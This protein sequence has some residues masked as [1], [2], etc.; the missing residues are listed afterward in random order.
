MCVCVR[1]C[2]CSF[3]CGGICNYLLLDGVICQVK[4]VDCGRVCPNC[5]L[6]F[7]T[8]SHFSSVRKQH[9]RYQAENGRFCTVSSTHTHTRTYTHTHT[10]TQRERERQPLKTH[11]TQTH[12]HTHTHT[13]HTHTHTHTIQ[14]HNDTRRNHYFTTRKKNSWNMIMI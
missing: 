14:T 1:V 4:Y 13:P 11:T 5:Y 12:T 8:Y 2:A 9:R 3:C 6:P 7:G 10:H